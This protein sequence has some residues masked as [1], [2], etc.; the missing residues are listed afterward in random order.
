MYSGGFYPFETP[1]ER[2]AYWSRYIFINRY[3][4]PPRPV[5]DRLRELVGD[6]DYFVL[7]TNV[8]H[9]FQ[10]AG[11]DKRRLFYTQGDYGLWQCSLP[12]HRE[13]IGRASCRERVSASV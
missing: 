1:E 11:F 12:C 13:K 10:R 3:E 9:C 6:R 7:T 4:P 5:Y 2:W 8:D